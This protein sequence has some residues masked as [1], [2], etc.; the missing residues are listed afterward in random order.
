MK[1]IIGLKLRQR[2]SVAVDEHQERM[3]GCTAKPGNDR[4]RFILVPAAPSVMIVDVNQRGVRRLF[5]VPPGVGSQ[6]R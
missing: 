4:F 2:T 1:V 3:Y 5:R 6:Q